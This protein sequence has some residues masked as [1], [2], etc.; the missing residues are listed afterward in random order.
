[1]EQANEMQPLPLQ[2]CNIYEKYILPYIEGAERGDELLFISPSTFFGYYSLGAHN[3]ER[4]CEALRNAKIRGVKI[5]LIIDI[6]DVFTAKAAEGFLSFLL[7]GHEV[8]HLKDNFHIYHIMVYSE[9][10]TSRRVKFASEM[11]RGLRYL[12]GIQVRPFRETIKELGQIPSKTAQ[13][14]RTEFHQIWNGSAGSVKDIIA[15]YSPVY[16]ARRYFTFL[17]V[18]TYLLVLIIGLITGVAFSLQSQPD[19]NIGVVLIWL[20]A[21]LGVGIIGEI[22]AEKFISRLPR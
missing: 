22:L 8:R 21:S 20:V 5:R 15:R 19:I 13:G 14:L 18:V 1:M 16:Q 3:F 7:D 4:V 12:P 17:Q 6:H 9:Q 2:T 10:G 11:P